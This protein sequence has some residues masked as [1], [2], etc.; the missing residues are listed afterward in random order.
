MTTDETRSNDC[1]TIR[2][3]GPWDFRAR[4]AFVASFERHE[5]GTRCFVV[6][7]SGVTDMDSSVLGLLL[8]LR[9]HALPGS[10][11]AITGAGGLARSHLHDA[12]LSSLFELRD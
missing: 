10:E 8:Q 11:V 9:D 6:D 1:V 5:K 3:R 2:V 12:R 4:Q 7:M